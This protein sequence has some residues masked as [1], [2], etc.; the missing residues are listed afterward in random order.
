MV[1]AYIIT[2][3]LDLLSGEKKTIIKVFACITIIVTLIS[4]ID[5]MGSGAR[6]ARRSDISSLGG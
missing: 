3:M 2:R 5:I 4:A 6:L 1:G